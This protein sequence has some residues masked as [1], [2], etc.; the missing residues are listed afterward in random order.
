VI[1]ADVF[2]DAEMAFCVQAEAYLI[3]YS[4]AVDRQLNILYIDGDSA[5]IFRPGAMD[6]QEMLLFG[7]AG[8]VDLPSGPIGDYE[9]ADL[10]SSIPIFE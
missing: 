10:V 7:R 8:D 4:T 5:S 2:T 1:I 3:S 6:S 9:R